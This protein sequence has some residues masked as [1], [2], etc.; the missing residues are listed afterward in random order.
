MPETKTKK[1]AK[2]T[3]TKSKT[4]VKNKIEDNATE[5]ILEPTE[6]IESTLP[7]LPTKKS[8][9][10][11][12]A[13][14]AVEEL[15]EKIENLTCESEKKDQELRD[16][17]LKEDQYQKALMESDAK[18]Q[19]LFVAYANLLDLYLGNSNNNQ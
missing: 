15:N 12:K 6:E 1:V 16:A 5:I 3:E 2:K 7:A 10:D 8:V 4:E 18:Y 9:A 17:A 19:K 11:K 14:K 13:E